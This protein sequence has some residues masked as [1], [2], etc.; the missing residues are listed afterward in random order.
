MFGLKLTIIRAKLSLLVEDEQQL[1][2]ANCLN[3]R[4]GQLPMTYLGFPISDKS[5]AISA[6]KPAMV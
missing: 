6:I 3:C 2:I 1:E 4:L 5:L